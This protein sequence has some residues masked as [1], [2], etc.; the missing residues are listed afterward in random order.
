MDMQLIR[1]E[2]ESACNVKRRDCTRQL[3]HYIEVLRNTGLGNLVDE[4]GEHVTLQKP[5]SICFNDKAKLFFVPEDN[6][7]CR[8]LDIN[9]EEFD[10]QT[11]PEDINRLNLIN[12]K[13]TIVTQ[14]ILKSVYKLDYEAGLFG[15]GIMPGGHVI[16]TNPFPKKPTIIDIDEWIKSFVELGAGPG[17]V[18]LLEKPPIDYMYTF[19]EAMKEYGVHV[20]S[21]S[22]LVYKKLSSHTYFQDYLE[23]KLSKVLSWRGRQD[24]NKEGVSLLTIPLN[25]AN[26]PKM[27]F[28]RGKG[29]PY[30]VLPVDMKSSPDG[31][32]SSVVVAGLLCIMSNI[33]KCTQEIIVTPG[34]LY[35][36][37]P[38]LRDHNISMVDDSEPWYKKM[39]TWSKYRSGKIFNIEEL[40]HNILR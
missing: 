13:N 9:Y 21:T 7:T 6:V 35:T 36:H 15:C 39:S 12:Y 20:V 14:L 33:V 18:V 5:R 3:Y 32:P 30:V 25:P 10:F 29:Y 28:Q 22:P 26:I 1:D 19:L 16:Q 23:R 31:Y 24:T 38:S 8:E 4:Y 37:I 34:I 11:P 2:I 27:D 40:L 17:D